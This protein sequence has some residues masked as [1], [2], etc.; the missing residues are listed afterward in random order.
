MKS[1][2][3]QIEKEKLGKWARNLINKAN[4]DYQVFD[5]ESEYDNTLTFYENK[6]ILKDKIMVLYNIQEPIARKKVKTQEGQ[7]EEHKYT[8]LEEIEKQ[9]E[10]EFN[11]TLDK[12]GKQETTK[13]IED[14][15][16][17]PKQYSKMVAEDYARGFL[18]FGEAGTGKTYSVMKAFQEVGKKF[19]LLTG[20]ITS[21]ELYHFLFE[22]RKEKIVLDDVNI[23]ESEQNLN[24]LKACLSEHSRIV[25]YHTTSGKLRV[26]NQFVFEGGIIILLN[27]VPKN[28]E[29]LRAVESRILNFEL[30]LD[31]KTKIKIFYELAKQKYKKLSG[32][33]RQE[34]AEWIKKNTN[35]ATENL[36]LRLLFMCYEFFRY[37]KNKWEKMASKLIQNNEYKKLIVDGLKA[38][39]WCQKTGKHRATYY[40]Y[41]KEMGV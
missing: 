10:L 8:Q 2:K 21:M 41:K 19:I 32:Q 33:E 38:E 31:Y 12:I 25:Q 36:N 17:I 37:N 26:P 22:H 24:M 29:S 30:K 27:D 23:L 34:I 7:Q 14:V 4:G 9:A 16:F 39:E 5:I 1:Q 15:Y 3:L 11:K 6:Q 13:A 20:H 35:E 18:L 28:S 40:R